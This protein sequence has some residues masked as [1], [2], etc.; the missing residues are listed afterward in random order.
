MTQC[1]QCGLKFSES[2]E[3]PNCS[4]RVEARSFIAGFLGNV[5]TILLTPSRFFRDMPL[6]GGLTQPLAF[7]LVT[8]W[9]GSVIGY[10]WATLAG[11]TVERMASHF[12]QFSGQGTDIDSAARM[13]QWLQIQQRAA[14]LFWSWFWGAG[15]ILLD[16]F[17]TLIT[18]FVTSAFVYVA[19][20]LFVNS[21]KQSEVTYESSIRIVSYGMTPAI[22]A[23][24]PLFGGFASSIY[25]MVVTIIGA[26]EVYRTSSSRAI[27]I[28]LFPYLLFIGII[29][30]G[31]LLAVVAAVKLAATAFF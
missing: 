11:S 14:H 20:R 13:S 3:C 4:H 29:G 25:V 16:P 21:S 17:K 31:I 2:T 15:S 12:V 22:L 8:H 10:F 26:R 7:A 9:I 19:A 6:S 27:L 5:K 1:P 18:I 24:L 23:A 28:V 30:L